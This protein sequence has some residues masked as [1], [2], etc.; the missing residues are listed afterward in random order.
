[1][2]SNEGSLKSDLIDIYSMA[3][4]FLVMY[5]RFSDY[6]IFITMTPTIIN[7]IFKLSSRIKE[8]FKKAEVK[9]IE[10]TI[11]L[12]AHNPFSGRTNRD[13]AALTWWL[14]HNKTKLGINRLKITDFFSDTKNKNIDRRNKYFDMLSG[15][16]SIESEGIKYRI[17]CPEPDEK[18]PTYES[19]IYV[20]SEKMDD[21][22]R[23]I[24]KV[25]SEFNDYIISLTK[26]DEC[27]YTFKSGDTV[28][29]SLNVQKTKDNVFIENNI[30][31]Y[32]Q[33]DT[34]LDE[35]S[36]VLRDKFGIPHKLGIMFCGVPGNGKTS[37]IYA[38][39]K[40][41]KKDIYKL[42]LSTITDSQY[43][44][45]CVS[46]IPK[47]SIVVF[48]EIDCCAGAL[49][50]E[51]KIDS[52]ICKTSDSSSDCGTSNNGSSNVSD[53]T[54]KSV[55]LDTLLE[56]LD[57]YQYLHKCIIIMTSNHPEKLDAALIRPGRIDFIYEFT[58]VSKDLFKRIFKFY[59][60]V[61]LTD[62]QIDKYYRYDITSSELINQI[63]LPNIKSSVD[64]ILE[65]LN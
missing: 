53:A 40:T 44:V 63:L 64:E 51:L 24:E 23:L 2:T 52:E 15:N 5:F 28:K 54:N 6:Y 3:S 13:H 47:D 9:K 4:P 22:Y 48:E 41:Y 32:E 18:R 27:I 25:V 36:F 17:E 58:Y 10:A 43:L 62:R 26:L 34:F 45:N 8:R 35:E 59:K 1:M 42:N 46:K 30:D 50:R 29:A 39:S 65:K 16:Y 7:I 20:H 49:S 61:E 55:R 56:I 38:L 60:D 33:I 21:C 37:L 31:I 19:T 12:E 11:K 57:G 14:Q